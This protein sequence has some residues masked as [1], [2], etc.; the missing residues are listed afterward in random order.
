MQ[1]SAGICHHSRQCGRAL[2]WCVYAAQQ[3][4]ALQQWLTI[5]DASQLSIKLGVD[6]NQQ[7]ISLVHEQVHLVHV[8]SFLQAR[9]TSVNSLQLPRQA[10]PAGLLTLALHK[11]LLL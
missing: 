8:L 10:A 7:R 1:A 5:R 9:A 2:S 4:A 11:A 3:S 6:N